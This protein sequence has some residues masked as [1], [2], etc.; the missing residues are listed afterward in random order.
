V[1]GRLSHFWTQWQ[2]LGAD[3]YVVQVL[4]EGY[5]IP[6][7]SRP[8][9]SRV[10]LVNSQYSDPL[11]NNVLRQSVQDMLVKKAIEPVTNSY[12]EG[13]YSRL[14]LVP[15]KT[16]EWRPVI[17]LSALN[18]FVECPTFKMDTPEHV[19]ASLQPGMW[20]TS[21]DLKDAYFHIPIHP[22]HRKFLRF[23]VLGKVFQFLAL[24]FGLN[25]APRLFTKVGAQLKKMGI[26]MGILLHQY[27]D[28]WLNR[29]LSEADVGR[30]TQLLLQLIDEL[31]W[32]VNLDKSDLI[33]T[34]VFEFLSYRFDLARGLVF[35]TEQRFQKLI[36]QLSP[37]LANAST[38]PRSVMRVLGLMEATSRQVPLGRLHMR[39]VQQA[40]AQLWDWKAPLDSSI[41]ISPAVQEH[42]RWWTIRGN[43]MGGVPLHPPQPLMVVYTDASMEGW[44]A[45]C[46]YH[47]AQG[48]WSAQERNLHINVLE[49][50]AVFNALKAFVAYLTNKPVHVATDNTTVVAYINKQGGTR[51]W[52]LCA[53]LWRLLVWCRQKNI[54]LTA[55]HIPGCL[56]VIADQL[57]RKGQALHTEWSLH[58]DIFRQICQQWGTPMIDLFATRFNN[59]L[60]LF[61]SPVPDPM[62]LE[63]DALSMDWAGKF[64]YA[65]PP[66]GVIPQVMNKLQSSRDCKLLLIAPYW[67]TKLWFSDLRK[68]SFHPAWQ[69][70]QV[71]YLLKQPQVQVFHKSIAQLDLHAWWLQGGW[72]I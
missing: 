14:F 3:P 60:P 55:R 1:G 10:P 40:L 24:P 15:K 72:M 65:F 37:L 26:R 27:I 44:G 61:V 47:I 9:L 69:L 11:K 31:G 19:R 39:P 17:D 28:D 70:P 42:I 34:Q 4:K 21:I 62:C 22:R 59:K 2:R 36:L 68:R 23:Q 7:L 56:N 30:K 53:L 33:P 51:S 25:T 52:E 63:V 8:P 41:T 49:L 5:K 54:V 57:S 18:K 38:T 46:S 58:P 71:W 20:V 16:G 13:F 67:P 6:F 64:L 12:S 32:I 50:K 48:S 45:H 29:A 43:V 66:T 35:P